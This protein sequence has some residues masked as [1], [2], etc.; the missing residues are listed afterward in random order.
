MNALLNLGKYLLALPLLAFAAFHF[1]N[2]EGMAGSVPIPGGVFWVYLI[3][4]A[5]IAAVASLFIGKYDKL[6][7][8]LVGLLMLIYAF[9]IYLPGAM[10]ATD[11]AIQQIMTTNFLKDLMIGG[12]AWLYASGHPRDKSIIG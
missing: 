12:G 6:A 1:M 5:Y 3:G 8:A 7:F 10:S 2:A 11:D 9:A 4:V